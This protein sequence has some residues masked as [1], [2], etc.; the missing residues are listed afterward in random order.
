M[1]RLENCSLLRSVATSTLQI[2]VEAPPIHM[3]MIMASHD[4]IWS[5]Y[6]R[7]RCVVCRSRCQSPCVVPFCRWVQVCSATSKNKIAQN[8]ARKLLL[9]VCVCFRVYTLFSALFFL[10]CY[11]TEIDKRYVEDSECCEAICSSRH[12]TTPLCLQACVGK[13]SVTT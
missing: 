13:T 9:C 7:T 1:S 10:H 8:P 11:S 2:R 3:T 6:D 5:Q 4:T 12:K